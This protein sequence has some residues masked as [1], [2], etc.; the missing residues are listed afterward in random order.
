MACSEPHFC[1]R[2]IRGALKGKGGYS[3]PRELKR[4]T[5]SEMLGR[6]ILKVELKNFYLVSYVP[7]AFSKRQTVCYHGLQPLET[8]RTPDLYDT[9]YL[10]LSNL[11]GTQ[12]TRLLSPINITP[13]SQFIDSAASSI[14]S[15]SSLDPSTFCGARLLECRA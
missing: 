15:Y 9:R 12:S 3:E 4:G 5:S 1:L 13:N 14:S 8:P 7:T 10:L 2:I 6:D 11:L